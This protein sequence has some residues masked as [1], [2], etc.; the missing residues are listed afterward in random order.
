[1]RV[2]RRVQGSGL[3]VKGLGIVFRMSAPGLLRRSCESRI[4]GLGGFW[5]LGF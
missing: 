5:G 1:M 2:L 4:S 3:M